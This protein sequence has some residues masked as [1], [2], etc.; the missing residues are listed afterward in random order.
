MT[1]DMAPRLSRTLPGQAP[2]QEASIV[3]NPRFQRDQPLRCALRGLDRLDRIEGRKYIIL[4][5]SGRDTFSKITLDK[6]LKKVKASQ[7]I[8]IYTVSTGGAMRAIT[9]GRAA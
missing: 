2:S 3:D 1:F 9:E 5:A 8:T 6:I 7:D 4:I